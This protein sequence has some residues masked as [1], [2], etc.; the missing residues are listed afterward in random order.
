MIGEDVDRA[1]LTACMVA[2]D[3]SYQGGEGTRVVV[4]VDV[5]F[6]KTG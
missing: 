3:G 5:D 1:C 2:R 4:G 6:S